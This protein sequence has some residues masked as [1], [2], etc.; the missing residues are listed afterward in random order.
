MEN[1]NT[2][3]GSAPNP[4]QPG[5]EV[6][7]S[8]IELLQ[9]TVEPESGNSESEGEPQGTEA[10]PDLTKLPDDMYKAVVSLPD[11]LGTA[12]V[13]ELKDAYTASRKHEG[14]ASALAEEQERFANDKLRYMQAIKALESKLPENATEILEAANQAKAV[15]DQEQQALLEQVIP[16]W[17]DPEI[18]R[19]DAEQIL[20]LGK[21]YGPTTV[22]ALAQIGDAGLMKLVYD[23]TKL[24]GRISDIQSKRRETKPK[25]QKSKPSASTD[26]ADRNQRIRGMAAKGDTVGAIAELLSPGS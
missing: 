21:T 11:E 14:Q 15:Y 23:Y 26:A 2:A 17:K 4:N 9:G 22:N 18:K 7:D 8:I 16:G 12:T 25:T 3:E 19:R 1:D 5:G 24:R 20:E 10:Q 13:E 6:E